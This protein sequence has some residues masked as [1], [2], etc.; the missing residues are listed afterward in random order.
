MTDQEIVKAYKSG[1]SMNELVRTSGRSSKG[2]HFLLHANG[3]E[4]RTKLDAIAAY[5][6]RSR[7]QH[8]ADDFMAKYLPSPAEIEVKTAEIRQQWTHK[9][10]LGRIVSPQ[11]VE[12]HTCKMFRKCGKSSDAEG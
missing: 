10:R 3:V 2:L 11:N 4:V 12:V 1:V 6:D 7:K 8:H 9:E 5:A